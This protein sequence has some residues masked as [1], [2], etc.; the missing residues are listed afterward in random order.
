MIDRSNWPGV[1]KRRF[2]AVVIHVLHGSA[3]AYPQPAGTAGERAASTFL[4][5]LTTFTTF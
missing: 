3:M 1:C 5:P 2:D 4:H